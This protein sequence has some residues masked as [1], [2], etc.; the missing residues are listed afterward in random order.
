[1]L[2]ALATSRGLKVAG[3]EGRKATESQLRATQSPRILHI[4]THGFFFPVTGEASSGARP[5]PNAKASDKIAVTL[6]NPMQRSGVALAGAE[7]TIDSWKRGDVPESQ[8]DGIVTAEEVAALELSGTWLVTLSACDTGLGESRSG[9]GVLGLRRGFV[10]SGEQNLLMTLWSVSDQLTVDMIGDFYS[11]ALSSGD[12]AK[13]LAQVQR[14][15]LVRLRQKY[16]LYGAVRLAGPFVLSSAGQP[17]S[18]EDK[19]E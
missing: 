11:K 12:A 7:L 13:A 2:E 15:W 3:Y 6:R 14:D 1:M 4:A 19:H 8:N 5:E 18:Q 10:Q 17:D 16:G 9:E